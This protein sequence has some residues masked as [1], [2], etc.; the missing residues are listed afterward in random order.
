MN[1]VKT[2]LHLP[3]LVNFGLGVA[4]IVCAY[5]FEIFGYYNPCPLCILQRWSFALIALCGILMAIPGTHVLYKKSLLLMAIIF[6]SCGSI[7]AG[8]QIYLQ[9]LPSDLVPTC[10]PPMDFLMETLPFFE[11]IQTI[12]LGDGNC[13]EYE[14]RFIFNFAEWALLFFVLLIFYNIFFLAK[15]S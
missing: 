7:I 9:N 4:L 8:R 6:A 12:L 13:A 10:A 3:S 15:K 2:I 14:W 5:I 11:V 1:F